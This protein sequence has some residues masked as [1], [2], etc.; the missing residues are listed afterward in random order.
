MRAISAL[1]RDAGA[2]TASCWALSALRIRVRKSAVASVIVIGRRLLPARLGHAGDHSL[3]RELAQADPA[4]AELAVHRAGPAAA[5]AAGVAAGLELGGAPGT[6]RLRSLGHVLLALFAFVRCRRLAGLGGGLPFLALLG[7]PHALGVGLGV[8]LF[9]L[10]ECGLLGLG[11]LAG[12][13]SPALLLGRPLL[14]GAR[15]TR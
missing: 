15:P 7:L 13:L 1:S 4:H 8:L 2:S 6:H 10:L 9:E 3:V 11:A 12:I 5:A 14:L